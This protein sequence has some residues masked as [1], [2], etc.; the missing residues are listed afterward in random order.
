MQADITGIP[1][2]IPAEKE[3]ALLGAGMIGSTSAGIFGSLADAAEQ[4]VRIA[5]TY[6]PQPDAVCERRHRQF[7]ALYEAMLTVQRMA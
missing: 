4:A 6:E 5:R 3:A 1:V 7:L 2:C